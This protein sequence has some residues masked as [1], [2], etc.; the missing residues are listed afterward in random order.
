MALRITKLTARP[1]LDSQGNWTV[2][3]SLF[4]GGIAVRASIPKGESAGTHEARALPA[5]KAV[6]NI[7][8][9]IA[10]RLKG[11]NPAE[12]EK[13]DALLLKLDGTKNKRRLGANA[14][15]AASIACARAG[16]LA[17]NTPLWRHLRR[18]GGFKVP[19]RAPR[20][21]VNLIEGGAHAGNGLDFQEYLVIPEGK[22]VREEV[23]IAVRLYHALRAYL[24]R[25]KGPSAAH[26]GDEGGFA[27]SFRDYREP[28]VVMRRVAQ[29][30]GLER[31]IEFGLDAAASGIRRPP[32]ELMARYARLI[33]EFPLIYLED[34]FGEDDFRNFAT[35]N[36]GWGGSVCITG[37]DLT[38]TNVSRMEKAAREEAVRGVIIKPNQIGT[39]TEAIQAVRLAR[40]YGWMV[41]ASH[42]GSETN[43]DFIADFAYG[44]GADGI[45]LGAPRRGERVAKYNRL[46]E[47]ENENLARRKN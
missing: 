18:I 20:L 40:T 11:M 29:A 47:I 43:D 30:L 31:K 36:R 42:R 44:V 16:A 1:E 35:L 5:E 39:V 3:A 24:V 41:I 32:R 9:I 12:Q 33:R 26:A 19:G 38:T 45:K 21:L 22:S 8:R 13:I 2:E 25:V 14:I 46:L 7:L 6:R 23:D 15:L 34:P 27:P 17:G 4:C 10:P 28:F 37:D